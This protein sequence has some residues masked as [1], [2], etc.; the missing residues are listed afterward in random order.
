MKIIITGAPG[1]GKGS[2]TPFIEQ[3]LNVPTISTGNILRA[4]IKAGTEL[5]RKAQEIVQS[6]GLVSD[7]I[8][9]DILAERVKQDDCKNGYILDGVPRTLKQ[10]EMMAEKNIAVDKVIVLDVPD[11]LIE[12][13]LV[14]R[15]VCLD[16]GATYNTITIPPKQEGVCDV[17]G[18]DIVI[19][20]DDKPEV[21]KDRLQSY[22]EQ[23]EPILEYY[24]DKVPVIKIDGSESVEYSQKQFEESIQ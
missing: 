18:K 13:R 19:R 15:R 9:L 4:E 11:S 16:C 24:S 12:Q 14:N 10:A 2:L 1:A 7:D 6:G 20:K 17:C 8:I 21:V 23:T 3:K 5:G 22:H